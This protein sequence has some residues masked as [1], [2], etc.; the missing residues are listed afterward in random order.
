MKT[1]EDV[2]CIDCTKKISCSMCNKQLCC[3][4][5]ENSCKIA[6]IV[7]QEKEE[8]DKYGRIFCADCYCRRNYEDDFGYDT[9]NE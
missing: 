4:Y 3:I 9:E 1:S 6:S 8:I 2:V 5:T 7:F